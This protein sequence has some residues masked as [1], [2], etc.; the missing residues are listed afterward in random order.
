MPMEVSTHDQ[1]SRFRE[2]RSNCR[3]QMRLLHS[4]PLVRSGGSLTDPVMKEVN[5]HDQE[6]RFREKRSNRR[7]PL[8]LLHSLPLVI[9]VH[10]MMHEQS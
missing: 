1:E 5:T 6:S 9:F 10:D 3:M 2:K 4:L 7:M 8:R